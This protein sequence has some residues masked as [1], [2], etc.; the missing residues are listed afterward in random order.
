MSTS[1]RIGILQLDGTI[2]SIY[3]H[4]DGYLDG[5][6]KMLYEHYQD[7]DKIQSLIRLGN[8]SGIR[9]NIAPINGTKH[10]FEH[11]Q[12]GVVIAYMRDRGTTNDE[13]KISSTIFNFMLLCKNDGVNYVYLYLAETKTWKCASYEMIMRMSYEE[14]QETLEEQGIIESQEMQLKP[15][16]S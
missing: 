1:S 12:E 8:V 4:W 6:G 13:A 14:L 2:K 3:C 15:M 11:P 5:V 10:S 9:E 16:G 7:Y